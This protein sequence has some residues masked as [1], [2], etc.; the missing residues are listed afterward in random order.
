MRT[1][2]TLIT[3]FTATM[4][5]FMLTL[6]S[7][8]Q[9][10]ELPARNPGQWEITM[11]PQTA[12]APPAMAMEICI[13]NVSDNEM[14][15]ASFALVTD[16]CSP[17]K[18]EQRGDAFVVEATCQVGEMTTNSRVVISGDFKK[19]YSV[20][21]TSQ[22]VGA[23]GAMAGTNYTRQEARWL[24]AACTNGMTPGEMLM[25]G[26]V[27]M[28]ADDMIKKLTINRLV[29]SLHLRPNCCVD[30]VRHR[31]HSGASDLPD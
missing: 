15:L 29:P 8:A 17:Q 13:D 9:D 31:A 14:M 11:V 6:A 4:T 27:K 20:E 7:T 19:A 16:M 26:T 22:V 23:M 1:T 18:I 5:L 28:N 25:P 10:G 24:G 12:G 30:V 3:T 21:I 2:S